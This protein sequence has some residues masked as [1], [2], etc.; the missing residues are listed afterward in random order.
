MTVEEDE[1]SFTLDFTPADEENEEE[2]PVP[3]RVIRLVPVEE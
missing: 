3:I 1:L 2:A